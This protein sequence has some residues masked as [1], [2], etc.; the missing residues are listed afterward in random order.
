MLGSWNQ[1]LAHED[2]RPLSKQESDTT[3]TSGLAAEL[4]GPGPDLMYD[5]CL[6]V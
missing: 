3:G 4:D 6:A 1:F 5:V 2:W